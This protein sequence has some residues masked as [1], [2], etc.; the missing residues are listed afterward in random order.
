MSPATLCQQ[1]L[2]RC[3]LLVEHCFSCSWVEE[4]QCHLIADRGRPHFIQV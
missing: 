1:S 3:L 2:Q 4:S